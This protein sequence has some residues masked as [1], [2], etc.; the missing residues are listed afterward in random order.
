M[1][2]K[3][4]TQITEEQLLSHIGD[5]EVLEEVFIPGESHK[6]E[7]QEAQDGLVDLLERSAGKSEAVKA[8]YDSQIASLEALIDQLSALPE[9]PSRTEYRGTGST[10][11]EIWEASDAQGRRRLLL[12]SGVRIEAAVADGPWVSVGRFERPERYD[13]AVSLG[14]SDNIQ[15]AFY[16]PKNLIERTTRLSR[17]SQLS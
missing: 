3:I 8:I 1:N 7:L 10:Y 11:R 6:E 16:L 13:E 9:T 4:L 17:G 5:L 15:Y 2:A 12:D 14:V